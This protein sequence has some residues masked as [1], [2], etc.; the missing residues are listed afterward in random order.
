MLIVLIKKTNVSKEVF[1]QMK[2]HTMFGPSGGQTY[3]PL[4]FKAVKDRGGDKGAWEAL[5]PFFLRG[6]RLR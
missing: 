6:F 5:R 1:E 4:I 2:Q 3:H